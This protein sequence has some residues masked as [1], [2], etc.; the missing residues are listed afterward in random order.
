MYVALSSSSSLAEKPFLSQGL[1]RKLLPAVP[2]SCNISLI[3]LPEL[4]GIFRKTFHE[5]VPRSLNG[6]IGRRISDCPAIVSL[7]FVTI[8]FPEQVVSLTS[9]PGDPGGP[10][11]L[12]LSLGLRHG[13]IR[14]GAWGV[15][16]Y[17]III[18]NITARKFEVV[19]LCVEFQL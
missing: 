5:P 10:I 18:E 6:F 1:L 14:H 9:N 3:S 17:A 2:I 19:G 7:D 4:P 13:P 12:L 8:F 15:G 16:H 11:G